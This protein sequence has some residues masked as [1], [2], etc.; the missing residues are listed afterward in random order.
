MGIAGKHIVISGGGSGVGAALAG[1]FCDAGARVTILGRGFGAL[2]KV[3][4]TTNALPLACDVTNRAAVEAALV[5]ARTRHGPVYGAIANA[6]AAISKPFTRT[7]PDDLS[8]M[9]AVNLTGTFNLWQAALPDM[10]EGGRL[11]A[12]ASTAGLKGYPYVSAYT[13]AKHAVVGLTRALA[14]ELSTRPITVN[15]ICP[16]FVD[17]P[18]LARS[19]ENIVATT[20]MDAEQARDALRT[21]NPQRRFIETDEIAG[22][23]LWLLGDGARSVTGHAL[24]ISGGEI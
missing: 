18:M 11:I 24:P 5:G 21:P 8:A 23:A 1:A 6:G 19:I 10:N 16:G 17:T 15:A 20:G 7:T 14:A 4:L 9:L 2:Q 12:I 3:A 13:A 22:A